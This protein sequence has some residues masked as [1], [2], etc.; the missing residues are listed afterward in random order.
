M[1]LD[2]DAKLNYLEFVDAMRPLEYY[3]PKPQ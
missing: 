1:D 3:S 2:C